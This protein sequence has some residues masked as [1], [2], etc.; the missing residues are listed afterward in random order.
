MA[1]KRVKIGIA[2]VF[3]LEYEEGGSEKMNPARN[4]QSDKEPGLPSLCLH[5][6]AY[7]QKR[8]SLDEKNNA[9]G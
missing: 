6:L 9:G 2:N 4:P 8:E 5:W 3:S 1:G 7:S